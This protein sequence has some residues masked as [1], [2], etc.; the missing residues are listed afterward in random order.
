[1]K[2]NFKQWLLESARLS[3]GKVGLYPPLYTQYYN[4]PPA[5][6]VTWS[7]D[8]ITYMDE[9]DLEQ[10]KTDGFYAKIIRKTIDAPGKQG[11]PGH[12]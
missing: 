10:K 2:L 6:I 1:M 4:Y 12:G 11:G 9:E 5:D 7:A 3:R 8:S